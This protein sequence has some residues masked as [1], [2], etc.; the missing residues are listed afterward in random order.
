MDGRM[1]DYLDEITAVKF[2]TNPIIGNIGAP[3]DHGTWPMEDQNSSSSYT[4]SEV[5]KPGPRTSFGV[6][7]QPHT[8]HDVIQLDVLR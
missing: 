7:A 4:D 1:T 3:L 6:V 5:W 2:A 8:P